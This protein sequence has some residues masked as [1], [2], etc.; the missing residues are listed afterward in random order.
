MSVS[1]AD[2][3]FAMDLFAPLGGLSSRKMFGG[4]MIYRDGQ[5]FALLGSS[6]VLYLKAG[7]GFARIMQNAGARQF[8]VVMKGGKTSSMGYW[9]LPEDALD[10]PELAVDW[11]RRALDHLA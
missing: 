9:S 3:A 11:A 6:G 1:D 10:D 8:S 7:D 5:T 4:L 2:I